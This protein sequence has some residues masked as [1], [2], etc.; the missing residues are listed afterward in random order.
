[1]FL[2]SLS[3]AERSLKGKKEGNSGCVFFGGGV[4]KYRPLKKVGN[5]NFQESEYE[6]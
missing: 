4:Y 2:H 3:N 5:G 1:M 6:I